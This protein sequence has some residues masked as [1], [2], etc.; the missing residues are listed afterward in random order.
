MASSLV[1]ACST[2]ATTESSG[3][4]RIVIAQ[5]VDP[6]S[7]NVTVRDAQQENNVSEQ[8][9]EKLIN[10]NVD[11]DGYE[12]VLA[13]GWKQVDPRTLEIKLRDGVKFTNGE[14]FNADSAAYSLNLILKADPY[15]GMFDKGTEVVPV[16]NLTLDVKTK[17]PS[18]LLL[19]AL[20]YSSFQFP[21]AY[22]EKVGADK[23]GTAPIGTGPF[24]LKE[25]ARGDH[26]D[27]TANPN[28]WRGKA[29]F[30]QLEFKVIPDSTSEI[31]ALQSGEVDLVS[32][33]SV[34]S[35]DQLKAST[36]ATLVSRLGMRCFAV[37]FNPSGDSPL[38]NVK[39]RQALWHAIDVQALIDQQLG[40][41]GAP[42]QGQMLTSNYFGFVPGTPPGVYGYDPA[43]A[44]QMLADAGYPN[45]FTAEFKYPI[46][47]YPQD[48]ELG[49]AIAGQL[50]KVGV[51]IKQ[52][53]LEGGAFLT[54]HNAHTL[55]DMYF[56]GYLPPPDGF[57]MY[58][59]WNG[60]GSSIYHNAQFDSL[61]Q[62][63]TAA[64]STEARKA[65]FHKIVDVV[66]ADPPWIPLLQ[67][68]DNYGVSK[69]ITGFQPR[70]TQL[71]VAYDLGVK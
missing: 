44:K 28:Y 24:A 21:K 61:L 37:M 35:F 51:K 36:N 8:I 70:A 4:K 68:A 46:G 31:A 12:P 26:I 54:A 63:S 10:F 59:I 67:G 57:F 25:W 41:K 38:K 11:A 16:D 56:A 39:V 20:A 30:D 48:K 64:T 27:M 47:L 9:T 7:L 65:T 29:K 2:G 6:G 15:K 5:S 62:Q 13:T 69:R 17:K 60:R 1:A 40:G 22:Y 66:R 42:L 71:L 58:D 19:N 49:Q 33:V 45:G 43:K 50:A 34:G 52:T 53:G 3:K 32:G 18:N 55:R 14:A 23:F